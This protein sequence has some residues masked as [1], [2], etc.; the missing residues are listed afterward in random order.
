[1]G[2]PSCLWFQ[3]GTSKRQGAVQ[4]ILFLSLVEAKVH[5]YIDGNRYRLTIALGRL[6][7]PL[8][9]DVHSLIV[10]P[11]SEWFQDLYLCCLAAAIYYS[12]HYSGSLITSMAS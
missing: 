6:E 7:P 5:F 2:P 4:A 11:H 9:N 10:K 1:G 8:L 12:S 3:Y